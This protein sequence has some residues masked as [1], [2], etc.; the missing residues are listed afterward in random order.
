MV[1]QPLPLEMRRDVKPDV[2]LTFN[3]YVLGVPNSYCSVSEGI[4]N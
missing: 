4:V 2:D 1:V 3:L